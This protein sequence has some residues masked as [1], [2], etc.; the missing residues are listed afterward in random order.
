VYARRIPSRR[1]TLALAAGLL[2]LGG[3]GGSSSGSTSQLLHGPG[4]TFR[5]PAAVAVARTPSS[6]SVRPE[7]EGT[8]ELASVTRFPLVKPFKPSLWPKAKHELD[9]VASRLAMGLVAKQT[10]PA[11][12]V[13][14][15]GLP[16]RRY[17]MAF[18]QNGTDVTQRLTLLLDRK[19]EYQL[20]CRWPSSDAEPDSCTL[21]E[22]T[23]EAG[24]R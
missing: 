19:R 9:G 17:V 10:E 13:R 21:L 24:G 23:F 1:S 7:D 14:V 3:C 16:G 2:M 20:L 11:S 6:V 18:D 22:T 15:G 8:L 12:T 4:F 5:A